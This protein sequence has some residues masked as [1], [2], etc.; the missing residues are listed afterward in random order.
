MAIFIY[1][2][3]I[4]WPATRLGTLALKAGCS[5]SSFPSI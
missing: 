5:W 3:R 2:V 4:H 1:F